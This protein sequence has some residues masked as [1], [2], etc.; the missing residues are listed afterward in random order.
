[1]AEVAVRLLE[2]EGVRGW[3]DLLS[4]EE[5]VRSAVER[6]LKEGVDSME[7]E[8]LDVMRKNVTPL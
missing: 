1:V 3:F 8:D 7:G 5:E 6:V 2:R 4:G